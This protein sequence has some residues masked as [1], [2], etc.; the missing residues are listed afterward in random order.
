MPAK[1][2][3]SLCLIVR[4]E[5][6]NL[7]RCLASVQGVV[8]E[9]VVVDTGS[10]DA[11][12]ALAQELGALVYYEPWQDDF[13][14]ARNASLGRATGD[15][16]LI[17]DADEELAEG[18]ELLPE[19]L[20]APADVE[21]YFLTI[22]SPTADLPGAQVLRHVN[23]RLFRRRAEY[24]F[25]GAIHEQIL[26]SILAARPN[27]CLPEAPVVVR[28][29]GYLASK[30]AAKAARNRAILERALAVR[31]DDPFLRYN[32]GVTRYQTGDYQAALEL[33]WPLYHRLSPDAGFYPSLVRSLAITLLEAGDARQALAVT[34]KGCKKF[35]DY[36]DLFYLRALALKRLYRYGEA[37]QVLE[38]LCRMPPSPR[39]YVNTLGV[40]GPLARVLLGQIR[41]ELGE[42]RQAAQC[43]VEAL[44]EMP[45]HPGALAGLVR[46]LRSRGLGGEKLAEALRQLLPQSV[47]PGRLGLL[48]VLAE[49]R[50]ARAALALLPPAEDPVWG[51][52]EGDSWR[53][54]AARCYLQA[55]QWKEALREALKV[56]PPS[57]AYPEALRTAVLAA[58]LAERRRLARHLLRRLQVAGELAAAKVWR[59][60]ALHLWGAAV[61]PDGV[62]LDRGDQRQREEAWQLFARAL[63]AGSR[64]HAAAALRVVSLLA[65]EVD[66]L[67]L[68]HLY[69]RYGWAAEAA[70]CY[71][72]ALEAKAVDEAMCLAMGRICTARE[73]YK[74]AATF[75]QQAVELN[76]SPANTLLL[77]EARLR[78]AAAL[79]AE[80]QRYFPG[81]DRLAA[82]RELV[83]V[84]LERLGR[85]DA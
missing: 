8:D 4:D 77:V 38:D 30:N 65:G 69:Y 15:W 62:Q 49:E 48:Q 52:E 59:A 16:V 79:L 73:L 6:Q 37:I 40:N 51:G 71:L 9:I 63:E 61:D 22:E 2:R 53:L 34:E 42:R 12:P 1:P 28:H 13:S 50:E 33:F 20:A 83:E 14:L 39:R 24:R 84:S 35:P 47:G 3:L 41:E 10:R 67:R 72:K 45:Q 17:L 64:R 5:A 7:A 78:E 21:G 75:Y 56:R 31:P 58:S 85:G 68:G 36:V 32:L 70:D 82:L 76:P 23:L 44:E 18:K 55:G 54:L 43:Y 19:L 25:C 11:T 29:H 27:A 26:P 46:V 81:S 57:L 60:Y 80:G 66:H 74:E